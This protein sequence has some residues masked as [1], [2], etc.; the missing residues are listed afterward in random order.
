M[1][2]RNPGGTYE[3]LP[4]RVTGRL[5]ET[6][7]LVQTLVTRKRLKLLAHLP[8]TG[9]RSSLQHPHL[10]PCP[11][12]HIHTVKPTGHAESRGI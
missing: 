4:R 9:G 11:G 6:E 7:G 3:A 12:A 5:L 8:L 1:V 2:R 10:M